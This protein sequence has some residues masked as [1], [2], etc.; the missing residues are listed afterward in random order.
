MIYERF[1]PEVAATLSRYD[2]AYKEDT[3]MRVLATWWH[4]QGGTD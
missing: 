3:L 4:Q 1:L 2:V